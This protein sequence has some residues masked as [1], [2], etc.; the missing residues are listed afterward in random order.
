MFAPVNR[1][2]PQVTEITFIYFLLNSSYFH[3]NEL[4]L[5]PETEFVFDLELPRSFEPT[6]TDDEVSDYY[7]LPIKEVRHFDVFLFIL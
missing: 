5:H 7:L 6:N 2:Y 1:A 3:E 4:G